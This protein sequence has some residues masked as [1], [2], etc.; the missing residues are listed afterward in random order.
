MQRALEGAGFISAYDRAGIRRTLGV[1]PP[2]T[3]DEAAGLKLAVQQGV[4][5]VVSGKIEPEARGYRLS[6]RAVRAVTGEM[7][8]EANDTAADKSKVLASATQ[9]A[10]EVRQALGDDESQ[11]AQQFA[12]ETLSAISLDV[13]RDYA[14]AMEALS[15]GEH[16][17]RAAGFSKAAERDPNFGLAHAGMAISLFNLR[18]PQ[19]AQKNAKEA[20]SHVA[21]MTERERFR[22]R[23]LFYLVTNDYQSCVKEYNDLIVRYDADAAARNNL[24]LCAT[25][26]RDWRRALD[27]MKRTVQILPKRMLF[28]GNLS[29]Y[30]SYSTTSRQARKQARA[31]AGRPRLV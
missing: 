25:Q 12:M 31:M 29:V 21:G 10:S 28:R 30:L 2:E 26:L 3:L 27:E 23:G 1:V 18:R 19:E 6:V 14:A 22:T 15:R 13:V 17:E 4:G 11:T 7:I 20:I 24:A 5:V 16:V 9:L 8:A